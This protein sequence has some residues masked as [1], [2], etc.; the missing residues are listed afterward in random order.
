MKT[1]FV[2]K[3][4]R[5]ARQIGE[6]ENP[7]YSRKIGSVIVDPVSNKILGTG[8]NGPPKDTP[9]CDTEEYLR[10]IFWPQLTKSDK[11]IFLKQSKPGDI[12][13]FKNQVCKD[14]DGCKIC[15]RRLVKAV[16]GQRTELCSCLHSER[17]AI[18]N[19][20]C[21]LQGAFIFC[22]CAVPCIQCAGSIINAG[23]KRVYCLDEERYHDVSEKLLFKAKV[24]VVFINKEELD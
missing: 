7:C 2:N 17:N 12:D 15:P 23:I 18:T 8:Y 5:L 13:S 19:A 20:S 14:F 9:H 4:M 1:K 16:S 11:E 21:N 22:Y 24:E 6:D 10:D 3:Y